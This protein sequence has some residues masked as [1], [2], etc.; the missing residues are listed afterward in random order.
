VAIAEPTDE[1]GR[2]SLIMRTRRTISG[3][4]AAAALIVLLL[5][6]CAA[7]PEVGTASPSPAQTSP[8][9]AEP[10]EEIDLPT[11]IVVA[12]PEVRVVD[13]TGVV[14][15]AF[16]YSG[17]PAAFI[18]SLTG[19]FGS[20][21][22]VADHPGD[23]CYADA[24]IASWSSDGFTV[25]YNSELDIE[26]QQFRVHTTVPEV[27]GIEIS[28]PSGVAVGEPIA[29]LQAE[30]PAEQRAEPGV[31]EGVSYD[32]VDYDAAVGSWVP[33]A[34]PEYG[35]NEYWGAQAVGRDG[36]VSELNAAVIFVDQC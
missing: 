2:Y 17:D 29:L 33:P 36:I 23:N 24:T 12:G 6:G 21:P 13:A 34:S 28:T 26:S 31:F 4:A 32:F 35:G 27:N 20:A 7:T 3:A 11:G 15:D 25:L 1:F 9:P 8:A 30:V 10:V 14:L 19:L 22:A 5:A 16:P 18:A